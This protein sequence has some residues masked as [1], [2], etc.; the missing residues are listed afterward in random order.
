VDPVRGDWRLRPESPVWR[1]GVKP[2]PYERMGL[3]RDSYRT[4]LPAVEVLRSDAE[5]PDPFLLAD[6]ARMSSERQW[7]AQ[8]RRLLDRVLRHQ[9]GLLP[10]TGGPVRAREVSAATVPSGAV[11]RELRLT[12]GPGDGVTFSVTLTVPK[13]A[14]PFPVIVCGDRGWGRIAPEIV[15]EVVGRGYALAEFN[16]EEVAPDG[17]QRA[18]VYAIW[19]D[20]TGGRLAAWAWGFH[21][22]VDVLRTLPALDGRRIAVTG[23]S[24]GGKAAL[25]AGAT[26]ERI[27][28][29]APNNS[30]CGGA[31]CYRIE[32]EGSEG[33]EAIVQR[34]PYWFAPGFARFIGRV[35][36]LPFDQHTLKAAVAPR[37]LLSTEALG[38]L[39]ANPLGSQ[40][41]YAAARE[42]YAFLGVPERIGIVFRPGGHRHT[43][44]D[45]RALLDFADAR[46]R[47]KSTTR[48]FDQLAF[49]D[50]PPGRAWKAP[51]RR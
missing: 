48:A 13:G 31:G 14:G 34:F 42:V 21:R 37:A 8:R 7:P 36:E 28:L 50:A 11:E 39:W 17:P 16:R 19:P 41:T 35:Q 15:A 32:G 10:P 40:V 3:Q 5:L 6:G 46:L 44:E 2:L 26:D 12:A 4:R 47:G 27:A 49:P 24:R 51:A 29:T 30:G 1:L 23:H 25:L 33:I 20:Y 9:Y 38:D 22:V 45:W 43:L 18:G